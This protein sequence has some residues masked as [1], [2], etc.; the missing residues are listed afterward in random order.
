MI[1]AGVKVFLIHRIWQSHIPMSTLCDAHWY[2]IILAHS[3]SLGYVGTLLK[4]ISQMTWWSTTQLTSACSTWTAGRMVGL[5]GS[6]HLC[7][8]RWTTHEQVML[9]NQLYIPGYSLA[10][11]VGN[12]NWNGKVGTRRITHGSQ[13]RIWQKQEWK[14]SGIGRRSARGQRQTGKQHG[15]DI[16]GMIVF[17]AG[18]YVVWEVSRR[19]LE[20]FVI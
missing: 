9:S 16:G 7:C 12:R 19:W 13:R 17:W 14:W 8:Y 10:E 1:N 18:C 20:Q 5:P 15:S 4:W 2:T 6:R 11:L 3:W